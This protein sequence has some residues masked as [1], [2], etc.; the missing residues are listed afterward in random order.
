M[1]LEKIIVPVLQQ[2]N[3]TLMQLSN[4]EYKTP[5]RLLNNVTIG[6]HTRHV[7]E[8][9]QCVLNGYE[10]GTINYDNRLRNVY[11]EQQKILASSTIDTILLSLK[12]QNK[13]LFLET[14]YD[15][16]KNT[17][18]LINTNYY[19]EII[20]NLEHTI[21]HMALIRIAI[22]E[23][24]SL[25]LPPSFGVASSTLQYKNLSAQ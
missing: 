6:A 20:Y 3:N 18:L 16:N 10:T 2:L 22:N 5:S 17:P 15:E 19:R 13:V 11:L 25:S 1:Q 23:L 9:F 7:I 8:L 21:H 24:T 4:E 14:V 12:K